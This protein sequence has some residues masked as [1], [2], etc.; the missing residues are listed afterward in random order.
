LARYTASGR[1]LRQYTDKGAPKSPGFL[2]PLRNSRR[3][4]LSINVDQSER[5]LARHVNDMITGA[6]DEIGPPGAVQLGLGG[7]LHLIRQIW[8]QRA[9]RYAKAARKH[10][11][12]RF[13]WEDHMEQ[14]ETLLQ[15]VAKSRKPVPAMSIP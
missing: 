4:A 15:D 7:D 5:G 14:I 12:S 11:L 1:Q 8:P 10:V 2:N 6:T 3:H 13:N 9:E